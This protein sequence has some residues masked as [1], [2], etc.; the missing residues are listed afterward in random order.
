MSKTLYY[1]EIVSIVS[2]NL[3]KSPDH[4]KRISKVINS[5][6]D[7]DD[8]IHTLSADAARIFDGIE[9]LSSNHYLDFIKASNIYS[10]EVR[11]YLLLGKVPDAIDMI[12]MAS[13]SLQAV[14]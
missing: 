2:A 6:P 5:D 3:H 4:L 9:D 12:S 11:D 14:K 7:Y 10:Y 8:T 13:N 1:G